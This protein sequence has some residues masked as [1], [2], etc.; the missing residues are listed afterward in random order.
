[1]NDPTKMNDEELID[2]IAEQIV[3]NISS[4]EVWTTDDWIKDT[5]IRG[6]DFVPLVEMNREQLLFAYRDVYEF[7]SE[8]FTP[9][10]E[11]G[12]HD[13]HNE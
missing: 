10:L 3:R 1:M 11:R 2:A 12:D 13:A 4:N 6:I 5:L 8:D 7:A 9:A